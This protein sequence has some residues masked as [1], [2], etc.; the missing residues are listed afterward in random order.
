MCAECR[1]YPCVSRCPNAPE[2]KPVHT[3][4]KCKYGIF[5]GEKF[6]DSSDGP[7]CEECMSDMD[8]EEILKLCGEEMSRAKED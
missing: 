3:C 7:I 5:G 2:P 6:F 8:A 1:S 4:I